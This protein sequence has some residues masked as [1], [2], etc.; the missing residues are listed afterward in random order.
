MQFISRV[1]LKVIQ[2]H[3]RSLVVTED[4]LRSLDVISIVYRK[5]YRRITRLLDN[6]IIFR[7]KYRRLKIRLIL[8]DYLD[9]SV[10]DVTICIQLQ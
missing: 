2:G 8:T 5:R 10:R 1:I 7:L 3:L 9:V 6:M 4:H